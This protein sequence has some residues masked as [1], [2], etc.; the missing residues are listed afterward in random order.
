[1][2]E[3]QN[4]KF[5]SSIYQIV[6]E[7]NN[8]LINMMDSTKLQAYISCPRKFFYEYVLAWRPETMSNHLIFG[9]A[10]HE[11]LEYLFKF[12]IT[13]ENIPP[14]YEKFLELYRK[15]FPESTDSWFGGKTPDNALKGLIEYCKCHPEDTYK[16]QVLATEVTDSISLET[17][18]DK[19]YYLTVKLDAI[20]FDKKKEKIII[21]E[22]KTGSAAGEW[23]SRQW[24]L[25][26][27]VGAYIMACNLAYNQDD[28]ECIIDG[29]FFLKTMRKFERVFIIRSESS[30]ENWYNSVITTMK[31]LQDDYDMLHADILNGEL[32]KSFCQN[33]L[34]CSN[35]GGCAY[36][37]ICTCSKDV[38]AI[39]LDRKI[40]NGFKI[41]TWNPVKEEK[42]KEDASAGKAYCAK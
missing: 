15:S 18:Y 31:R 2:N 16:W 7:Q 40:V 19:S 17:P 1:M 41:E 4:F 14:A 35:Y 12:G 39:A 23:W 29:A 9:Q 8:Y 13:V 11:A 22:H 42:E 21:M 24:H 28:T 32:S 6:P 26:L 3:I 36:W 5:Y 27:Q 20:L 25:S 10:W 34:A 37:D 38:M 33:P 30:M